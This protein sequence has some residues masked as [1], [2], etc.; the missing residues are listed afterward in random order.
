MRQALL[1]ALACLTLSACAGLTPRG[2]WGS[3]RPA[4]VEETPTMPDG[5]RPT[6]S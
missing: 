3:S 1:A 4:P 2:D 5:D 6:L